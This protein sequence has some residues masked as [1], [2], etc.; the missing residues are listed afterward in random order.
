VP[1]YTS[2]IV[3]ADQLAGFF[4]LRPEGGCLLLD[5][6]YIHPVYQGQGIGSLVLEKV[7]AEADATQQVVKVGALRESR[8]NEFYVRSGFAL[9][10][11]AEHDN[12]YER[13]PQNVP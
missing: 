5:H 4:V 7:F 11:R 10:E 13:L 6:L 12:Y 3:V 8:S 9:V 2:A 1:A